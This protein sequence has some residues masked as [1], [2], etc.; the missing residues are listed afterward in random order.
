MWNILGMGKERTA[1]KIG[2]DKR[3]KLGRILN[4]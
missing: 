4:K 1:R 3:V 2:V